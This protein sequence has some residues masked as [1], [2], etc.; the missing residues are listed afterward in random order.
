MV[1]HQLHHHR[2]PLPIGRRV[3]ELGRLPPVEDI[4][5]ADVPT[6]E[7]RPGTE[8]DPPSRMLLGI[9]HR[10][11]DL[12]RRSDQRRDVH[13]SMPSDFARDPLSWKSAS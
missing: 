2:P 9:W 13:P 8:C 1:L 10:V 4:G 11:R 3:V 6:Y 7:E 5:D 12:D